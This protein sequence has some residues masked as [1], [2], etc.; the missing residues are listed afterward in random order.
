NSTGSTNSVINLTVI[1]G[2]GV[3]TYTIG[4]TL[5]GLSGTLVL[6]NN[7]GDNLTLSANGSFTFATALASSTNYSVTVL[8]QPS[9]QTCS[10]TS[11]GSG[12]A[13]A[14]VTNVSVSC[15]TTT[16]TIGGSISGLT[17][18][19]LVLQNNAGDNLTV[20]SGATSF[21]FATPVASG[22]TYAVTVQTHPTGQTCVVGSGSGTVA[23]ANVTNVSITCAVG[24]M[25]TTLWA[26]SVTAGAGDSYFYGVSLD[27]SGN[28][29]SV[30]FISGN[31]GN[32][33]FGTGTVNSNTTSNSI[34]SVKYDSS[35]TALWTQVASGGSSITQAL[36]AAVDSNGNLITGGRAYSGTTNLGANSLTS[37][38]TGPFITKYDSSGANQWVSAPT[39][40]INST[41]MGFSTDSSGNIYAAG[42]S[43]T[44]GTNTFG[45]GVSL[46]FV[47]NN[48]NPMIV[49]YDSSGNPLWA[50]GANPCPAQAS[51]YQSAVD[52]SGNVYAVGW[53]VYNS[54]YT[55]NGGAGASV[56]GAYASNS[57]AVIVKYDTNGN[58]L[59]ARTTT[60]APDLSQFLGVTVDSS[61][62]IYAVGRLNGNG[63]FNFGGQTVQG[64]VASN[65]NA[66]IVKYDP[67]GN[68]LWAKSTTTAPDQST[69]NKVSADA[70]GNAYAV[71]Y[72]NGAS[73]FNFGG[74]TVQG[75]GS[76]YNALIV[77]YSPSGVVQYAKS[78]TAGTNVSQFQG[79]ATNAFGNTYA[80]GEI[81]CNGVYN[82][83]TVGTPVNV[84]GAYCSGNTFNAVIVKYE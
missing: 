41:F 40:C 60:T 31:A 68:V 24:G 16:Y 28:P 18:S 70:A 59:W 74:V 79:V 66:F 33:N 49:K 55:F 62:N 81:R 13:T 5:S 47:V 3:S 22:A 64:N 7:S 51:F 61:G 1:A 9:G 48:V 26:R 50:R 56:A 82:F 2:G 65:F 52:S 45:S 37:V 15:G 21:T 71:G 46:N 80:V 19:G 84:N 67:N 75:S 6:Q 69:F 77:K 27:S 4:G 39:A 72:I 12:T 38:C 57:N 54:T 76:S 30:G 53:I 17:A 35:G 14:N 29:Y 43:D 83:G 8:T 34:V 10:V 58:V 42:Y 11:G 20:A 23:S 73:A 63:T 44:N 78:T 32:I 36:A 25:G